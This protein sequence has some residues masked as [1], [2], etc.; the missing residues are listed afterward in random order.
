MYKRLYG[1]VSNALINVSVLLT[2]LRHLSSLSA[3]GLTLFFS[4]TLSAENH[5]V[6]I[7]IIGG[8]PA[9]CGAGMYT[10][11]A[12][13]NT[14]IFASSL[15]GEF[16]GADR[17]VNWPA[18]ISDSGAG[19]M[20]RFAQQ[21]R[22][23]G[24]SVVEDAVVELLHVD[25]DSYNYLIT[26]R[27]SGSWYAK[28]VIIATGSSPRR[29]DIPGEE[30]YWG[31]G[32]ATC[33]LCEAP[34]YEGCDVAVVGAG[35]S[36]FTKALHLAKYARSVTI[37]GRKQV[38]ARPIVREALEEVRDRVKIELNKEVIEV[39]GD[40]DAVTAVMVKDT[41]T[42]VIERVPMKAVFLAIGSKPN[43]EFLKGLLP[44]T[45]K[46]HIQIDGAGTST[47]LPGLF[48]AGTVTDTGQQYNQAFI[49][50][51]FG[52]QAGID[53]VEYVRYENRK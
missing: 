52:G 15:G 18:T 46:G 2:G 44:L 50:A 17:V 12:R 19:I 31:R 45:V 26:T 27:E 13:L 22:A 30:E 33:A 40:G 4:F 20:D 9:G 3:I 5:V 47:I 8:G 14:V 39:I 42:G 6:D 24:V 11:G 23:L 34:L 51:G 28:S 49:E 43:T 1:L 37:Y 36:A 10:G 41:V 29:L 38:R 21:V 7:A 53:A 35:D 48:A 16:N 32:V 25:A